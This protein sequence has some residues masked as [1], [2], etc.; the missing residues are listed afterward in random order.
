MATK[1]LEVIE[2]LDPVDPNELPGYYDGVGR[3][4]KYPPEVVM[5]ALF[6]VAGNGGNHAKAARDLA[7]RGI[8][9]SY[10]EPGGNPIA[11]DVLRGWTQKRFRNRFSEIKHTHAREL[12]D[13]VAGHAIDIALQ[14]HDAEAE[15]LKQTLAGIPN[16]NGVEAS[17]A[18]RNV[19]QSKKAQAEMALALRGRGPMDKVAE[20]LGD[21]GKT[22]RRLGL[23]VDD[24]EAEEITE[25][26]VVD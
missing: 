4:L 8:T 6:E 20:S 10:P 18:L 22:L 16:M 1:E 23:V 5:A 19:T 7:E 25:A 11:R 13:M 12:E 3:P 9:T 2:P 21:I 26:E 17:V 15:L 14:S 24:E